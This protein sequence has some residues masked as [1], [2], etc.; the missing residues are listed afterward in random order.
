MN[1]FEIKVVDFPAK[2]LMGI[3]V[4]TNMAKAK[5]DCPTL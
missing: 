5:E 1:G 3:K 2:Q 4:R